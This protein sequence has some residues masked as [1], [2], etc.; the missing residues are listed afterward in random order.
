MP[1]TSQYGTNSVLTG[2]VVDYKNYEYIAE[3]VA[4]VVECEE[5][6]NY[7]Y[8][9]G[10]S[11][12]FDVYETI[13]GED[14][15]VSESKSRRAQTSFSVKDYAHSEFLPRRVQSAGDVLGIKDIDLIAQ[16]VTEVVRRKQ[17]IDAASILFA[18]GNYSGMTSSPGTKWGTATMKQIVTDVNTALDALVAPSVQDRKI[19]VMGRAA[20][21][22]VSTNTNVLAAITPTK[23]AGQ[24]TREQLAEFLGVDE[25]LVGMAKKNTA[26]KVASDTLTMGDIWGD[27]ALVCYRSQAPTQ[28]GATGHAITFR[29]RVGGQAI[30]VYTYDDPDRGAHGG[31]KIKVALTQ[32][33]PQLV[34]NKAG[35]LLSAISA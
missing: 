34:N 15:A 31:T 13:A 35:Y 19:I 26:T 22:S 5:G 33:V 27:H 21:R 24:A 9:M 12:N 10:L 1:T 14:A 25:I 16:R 30:G 32:S 29:T 6:Q 11:D 2:F 17:E 4:P 7:Y 18:T 3:L 20:W 23:A 28:M 8:K